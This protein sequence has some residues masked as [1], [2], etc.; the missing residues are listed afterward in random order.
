[1][2]VSREKLLIIQWYEKVC[3]NESYNIDSSNKKREKEITDIEFQ[4][5]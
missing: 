4:S 5:L 3:T 1:M 2:K